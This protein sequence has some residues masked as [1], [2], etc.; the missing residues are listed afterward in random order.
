[1]DFQKAPGCVNAGRLVGVLVSKRAGNE[2]FP[3]GNIEVAV[4]LRGPMG[5]QV[6]P[7]LFALLPD[8]GQL[9][10]IDY[11]LISTRKTGVGKNGKAYAMPQAAV[12]V[13]KVSAG[14]SAVGSSATEFGDEEDAGKAGIL[15]RG[16][17]A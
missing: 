1:M 8:E 2:Q 11:E 12:F 10:S 14:R 7:G 17:R 9:V 6:P 13:T 16:K 5:M 3:A 4:D 15:S